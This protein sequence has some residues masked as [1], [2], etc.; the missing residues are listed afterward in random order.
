VL[1]VFHGDPVAVWLPAVHQ[2]P[3]A[4]DWLRP[5]VVAVDYKAPANTSNAYGSG[6]A[7]RMGGTLDYGTVLKLWEESMQTNDVMGR[8]PPLSKAGVGCDPIVV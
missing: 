8:T 5:P 3:D 2:Q 4:E 1:V 6:G 7:L